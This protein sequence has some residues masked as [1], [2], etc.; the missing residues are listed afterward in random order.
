MGKG[1]PLMIQRK[2]FF[3]FKKDF[4]SDYFLLGTVLCVRDIVV[5]KTTIMAFN[6]K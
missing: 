5:T 6:N 2:N 1:E 3:S 4:L